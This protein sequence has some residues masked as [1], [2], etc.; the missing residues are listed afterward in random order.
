[1]ILTPQIF[2]ALRALPKSERG[3]YELPQA[4][5][6]LIDQARLV[7]GFELSGFWSD[8]GTVEEYNRVNGLLT[9]GALTL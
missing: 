8:V 5:I 1:M 4:V 2:P 3:E 9:S 7:L 6:A